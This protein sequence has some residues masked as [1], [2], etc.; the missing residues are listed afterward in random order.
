MEMKRA[1]QLM[2]ILFA[3]SVSLGILFAQDQKDETTPQISYTA[4]QEYLFDI[5]KSRRSVRQFKST[6]IPEEHIKKI[7]DIARL[8]PTSGNQQPWKFL[9]VQD[10]E[11]INRLQEE[12]VS[13]AI[14]RMKQNGMTDPEQLDSMRLRF[15]NRIEGYLSAP[16]HVVVLVD[17]NSNYP[18]YNIYDGT[19]AA[20]Y[21]MIA[22]RALDF[23]TVFTTDS[24]PEDIV[25][26]VYDIPDNFGQIC[27][28][29]IG[30]P[31]S[32]PEPPQKKSLDEFAV[33]EKFV[34]GEKVE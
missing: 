34:P 21:L 28:I 26:K 29:P 19:L 15:N 17:S 9:V 13:A 1:I 31:D 14:E 10:R 20:G 32:W 8:A 4:E 12:R 23:G 30:V 6:P 24:F 22:A 7:L 5:F 33:F 18:S 3:L 11:K 16:V 27:Y 25:R 2:I